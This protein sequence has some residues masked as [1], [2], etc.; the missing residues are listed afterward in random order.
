MHAPL[1]QK[2]AF[3]KPIR[4]EIK[5]TWS[6]YEGK[7]YKKQECKANRRFAAEGDLVIGRIGIRG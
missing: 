3:C 7:P 1:W 4:Q 5:V 2:I 6:V